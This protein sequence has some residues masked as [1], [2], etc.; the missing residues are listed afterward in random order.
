MAA[1]RYL[2]K[3][4]S[5]DGSESYTFGLQRYQ[6]QPQQQLRSPVSLVA[7]AAY[8]FR[9]LGTAPALKNAATERVRFV[10][11]D[12][13]ANI[14][15][16]IDTLKEV[17][18]VGL[19]KLWTEGADASLRWAWAELAEMPEVTIEAGRLG[20]QPVILGF[21]RFSDWFAE[22]QTTGSE[23]LTASGQTFTITNSGN[24]PVEAV[25]F[26]LRSSAVNGFTNPQLVND[27]NDYEFSSTSDGATADHELR[28]DTETGEVELSDDDGAT[29]ANDLAQFSRGAAQIVYMRLE[30][31]ANSMRYVDGGTV[32]ADLEYAFSPAFH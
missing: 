13:S 8:S 25:V 30:P 28:V 14:D 31:G 11:T 1:S 10:L 23:T 15:T 5:S 7:G 6:W 12:T 29:Y 3:F 2:S 27:T 9:H 32:D 18:L 16:E 20:F 19:G 26:R 4:T 17:G 22:T 21:N 24:A